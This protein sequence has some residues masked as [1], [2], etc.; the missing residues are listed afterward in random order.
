MLCTNSDLEGILPSTTGRIWRNQDFRPEHLRLIY[1]EFNNEIVNR[2][3]D[4][5]LGSN[6]PKLISVL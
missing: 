1:T 6:H 3:L 5:E 4:G 2:F